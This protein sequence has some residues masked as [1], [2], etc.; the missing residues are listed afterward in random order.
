M[1]T[2]KLNPKSFPWGLTRAGRSRLRPYHLIGPLVVLLLL[3]GERIVF[4]REDGVCHGRNPPVQV[5]ATDHAKNSVE[6]EHVVNCTAQTIDDPGVNVALYKT[7]IAPPLKMNVH[8]GNEMISRD[9]E[10]SGCFECSILKKLMQF[11]EQTPPDT[12]FLDIGANIGMYSVHAAAW[13]RDVFAF[14]P[15]QRNYQRICKSISMNK[16][17]EERIV[18]FN[19]ALTDHPTTVGF[20][21]VSEENFG[22]IHVKE[23]AAQEESAPVRGVDYAPGVQLSSL[24][25]VLPLNRPAV[26]KIDVEGSECGVLGGAMDYLHALDIL[27]V[28]MEWSPEMPNCEHMEAMFKLF[29]K[30]RLSPYQHVYWQDIWRPVKATEWR[31][32]HYDWFKDK[33]WNT[34]LMDIAWIRE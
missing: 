23:E 9:I 14:E 21:S 32:W 30:N 22:G 31:Q 28:A 27:Y 18:V 29:Q 12:F 24:K 4:P 25:S 17:F 19:I 3:F 6:H 7:C 34:R 10:T 2:T 15:F 8:S 26:I 11:M 20:T 1:V 5:Q 16:G 33:G 13:G